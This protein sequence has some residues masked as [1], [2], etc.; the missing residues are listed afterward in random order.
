MPRSS[1]Y[2]QGSAL[3]FNE[4]M[5]NDFLLQS[6]R[7]P[8]S[9]GC[10]PCR[11]DF[12]SVSPQG[13]EVKDKWRAESLVQRRLF[14]ENLLR[15]YIHLSVVFKDQDGSGGIGHVLLLPKYKKLP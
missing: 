3:V 1:L 8:A 15:V 7:T 10:F 11:S 12:G 4:W 9:D 14:L 6:P 2:L 5:K 13:G